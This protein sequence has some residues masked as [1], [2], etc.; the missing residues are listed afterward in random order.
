MSVGQ[1]TWDRRFIKHN[2]IVTD[3]KQQNRLQKTAIIFPIFAGR[4]LL[5]SEST[6]RNVYKKNQ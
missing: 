2:E 5:C 1:I 4:H 6:E 3:W